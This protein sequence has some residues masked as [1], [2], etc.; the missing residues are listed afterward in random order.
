MDGQCL[1]STFNLQCLHYIQIDLFLNNQFLHF[2]SLDACLPS[3]F[4]SVPEFWHLSL[5]SAQK[6]TFLSFSHS[7]TPFHVIYVNYCILWLL[8]YFR[9]IYILKYV[10]YVGLCCLIARVFND[11]LCKSWW[12]QTRLLGC[13]MSD[14]V[15][16]AFTYASLIFNVIFKLLSKWLLNESFMYCIHYRHSVVV[17]WMYE[18]KMQLLCHLSSLFLYLCL[19]FS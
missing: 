1:S 14:F 8:L 4:S 11:F 5:S 2:Y 17:S 10:Y 7:F 13:S 6:S 19:F 9:H 15:F 18:Y 16:S 3:S 12:K